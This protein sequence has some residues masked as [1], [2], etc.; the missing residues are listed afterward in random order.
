[1]DGFVEEIQ[2]DLRKDQLLKFWKTYA[3]HVIGVIIALVLGGAG[4]AYWEVRQ[5]TLL[6][7]DAALY[8]DV[9]QEKS[10]DERTKKLEGLIKSRSKGYEILA[11]FEKAESSSNIA[12]AYREIAKNN[13]VEKSF[14]D[15]ALLKAIMK[16]MGHSKATLLLEEIETLTKKE[17][18][19]REHA[20]EIEA[21]LLVQTGNLQRAFEIYQ[22]LAQNKLAA[23][24]IRN[25]SMAMLDMLAQGNIR[26]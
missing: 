18:P 26:R 2:E 5:D 15:L 7:K 12:N 10:S 13:H 11:L 25:R 9:L 21:T 8:E 22:S 6:A 19:W 1:M 23:T 16:D 20:F 17:S 3:N 4:Y 24:G 14:R